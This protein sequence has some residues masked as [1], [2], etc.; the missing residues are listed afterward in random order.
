[1]CVETPLNRRP[2]NHSTP[3]NR[4]GLPTAGND[5]EALLQWQFDQHLP[6]SLIRT[7]TAG[8]GP[9]KVI[10]ATELTEDTELVHARFSENAVLSVA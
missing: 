7:F 1:V 8:L 2:N 4:Y 9:V 10:F 5:S 6:P 3:H